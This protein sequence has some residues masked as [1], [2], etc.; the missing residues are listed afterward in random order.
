LRTAIDREFAKLR[1]QWLKTADKSNCVC[2]FE[3]RW[4]EG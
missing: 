1:P 4:L 3:A 2:L